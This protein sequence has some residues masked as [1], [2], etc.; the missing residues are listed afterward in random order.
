MLALF[1]A[2]F[3]PALLYTV[4]RAYRAVS[5]AVTAVAPQEAAR[6]FTL[7][8]IRDPARRAASRIFHGSIVVVLLGHFFIFVDEV[9]K[10]LSAVG[11]A[12]GAAAFTA[13]TVA[14]LK[15]RPP[16]D[17]QYVALYVLTAATVATGLALGLTTPREEAVAAARGE[18][19]AGGVGGFLLAAHVAFAAALAA[20]MPFTLMSHVAAPLVYIL[21][22]RKF[23]LPV[24]SPSTLGSSRRT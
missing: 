12:L 21:V 22:R 6:F 1:L 14:F 24:E 2:V 17:R 18:K 16:P 4:Y 20:S 10:W 5:T 15:N 11:A 23:S 13:L 19:W 3:I 7:G 9:P 8:S